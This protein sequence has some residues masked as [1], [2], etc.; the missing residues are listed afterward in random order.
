[1]VLASVILVQQCLLLFVVCWQLNVSDS[2]ISVQQI[3]LLICVCWQLYVSSKVAV[4][5]L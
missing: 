5:T 1:M 4:F 2:D 3:L